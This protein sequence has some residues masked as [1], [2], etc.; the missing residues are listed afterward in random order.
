MWQIFSSH[1]LQMNSRNLQPRV[2]YRGRFY[3]PGK[4]GYYR[5]TV[6]I[7]GKREPLHH[8]IWQDLTGR[9]I[10]DGWQVFFKDGDCSNFSRSNLGCLPV[11]EVTQWHSARLRK[12]MRWTNRGWRR[13]DSLICSSKKQPK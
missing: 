11:M 8:R 2:I 10:P 6:E 5:D 13:R 1:G 3:T 4:N 7:E 9:K 12:T